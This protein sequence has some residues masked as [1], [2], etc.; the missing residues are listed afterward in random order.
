MAISWWN[1]CVTD[2]RLSSALLL[3]ITVSFLP[4]QKIVFPQISGWAVISYEYIIHYLQGKFHKLTARE[5]K[6]KAP[7]IKLVKYSKEN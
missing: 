6:T 1:F 2:A 7:T 5:G 4:L 3:C